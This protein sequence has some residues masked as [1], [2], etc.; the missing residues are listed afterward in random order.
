MAATLDEGAVALGVL[1][2][3]VDATSSERLDPGGKA[4]REVGD[5]D[6]LHSFTE[7]DMGRLDREP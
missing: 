7:A 4:R 2:G 5:L 6:I 3:A 1:A